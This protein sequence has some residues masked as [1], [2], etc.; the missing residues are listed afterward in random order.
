[1]VVTSTIFAPDGG[2][3][4]VVSTVV[5]YLVSS[6]DDFSPW[7]DVPLNEARTPAS[8]TQTEKSLGASWSPGLA[9]LSRS[10]AVAHNDFSPA[11]VL[12]RLAHRGARYERGGGDQAERHL[13]RDE[14][15][16][17]HPGHVA[18][19]RG[20]PPATELLGDFWQVM[21]ALLGAAE[22]TARRW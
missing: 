3:K 18:R 17:G 13:R 15:R 5:E 20:A 7:L 11:M 9:A 8:V 16:A 6:M 10:V 22:D 2:A 1:M 21:I 14:A 12:L 4:A 19:V